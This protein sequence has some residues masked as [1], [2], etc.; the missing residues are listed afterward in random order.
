M[1]PTISVIMSV[2]NEPK[3]W[4]AQAVESI[5]NQTFNDFE[6]II[7]NDNPENKQSL[8]LL[9]EYAHDDN[10]IKLIV[11]SE[12]IGLTR[13]LNKGLKIA[14]GKYIA[15]MD[16]DDVSLPQRFEKQVCYMDTHS[17]VIV[18]GT[19]INLYGYNSFYRSYDFIKFDNDAIKAQMLFINP[20]AHSTVFIR[21]EILDR[22]GIKYD[23]N[24]RQSQDYRLWEQL[25]PY[26]DFVNLREKLLNY[27]ISSQQ[28][29]H[30][31]KI[32]QRNLATSISIRLQLQWLNCN[33]YN[34]NLNELEND[35]ESI[36][37]KLR[38]SHLRNTNEYNAFI[39]FAYLKSSSGVKGLLYFFK[40]DWHSFSMHNIMRLI[41][42]QLNNL[43]RK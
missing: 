36:V 27:R 3:D 26:G 29:S 25:F 39:Q 20:I 8:C 38:F 10:R 19:N 14:K 32:G 6:F 15:R 24:Y 34:Y 33:G 11:N 17:N 23:E 37:D 35:C 41:K 43:L 13:S 42:K 21:K 9:E 16:A 28:V 12:N 18:L 7:I 5:C 1:N 4:L 22:Y 31:S 2:F 40:Y 30:K